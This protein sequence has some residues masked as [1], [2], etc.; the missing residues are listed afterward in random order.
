MVERGHSG[1]QLGGKRYRVKIVEE[2]GSRPGAPSL[3]RRQW[4][5][6]YCGESMIVHA[7]K[8]ILRSSSCRSRTVPNE[9][10]RGG[11]VTSPPI[12][13]TSYGPC[14][15]PV[16]FHMGP[17]TKILGL[18]FGP[19]LMIRGYG[20]RWGSARLNVVI[21]LKLFYILCGSRLTVWFKNILF[22]A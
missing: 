21:L 20:Y 15:R 6:R 14:P 9:T 4:R 7:K 3:L 11:P 19:F 10:Y 5:L 16:G 1:V 17:W 12:G 2:M 8:S 22:N 18:A 13:E